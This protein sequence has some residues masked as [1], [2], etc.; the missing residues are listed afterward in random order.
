[1]KQY[2][3]YFLILLTSC[4]EVQEN[5]SVIKTDDTTEAFTIILDSAFT[6]GHFNIQNFINYKFNDSIIFVDDRLVHGK[7]PNLDKLKFKLLTRDSICSLATI[8]QTNSLRFP[9]ILTVPIFRKTN[10][11]YQIMLESQ[12]VIPLYDKMGKLKYSANTDTTEKC[13]YRF[14]CTSS[15]SMTLIYRN[16]SIICSRIKFGA[17]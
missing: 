4:K 11:G 17:S 13:W 5:N 3:F 1:M 16:D 15:I 9:D 8:N 6:G 10:S 2:L 14:L 12:C 7:L